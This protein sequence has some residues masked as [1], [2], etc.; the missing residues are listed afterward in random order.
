MNLKKK[1]KWKNVDFDFFIFLK[2]VS[3]WTA[4]S[5]SH[6]TNQDHL[7]QEKSYIASTNVD[8]EKSVHHQINI[9]TVWWIQVIVTVPTFIF[10][11]NEC[12][13]KLCNEIDLLQRNFEFAFQNLVYFR[14]N[15]IRTIKKHLVL[16]TDL[17]NIMID[18]FVLINNLHLSIINY[19]TMIKNCENQNIY[20]KKKRFWK[21]WRCSWNLLHRSTISWSIT[22]PILL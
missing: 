2:D 4:G 22:W 12:L 15:I 11:T 19:E 3:V 8:L 13:I 18:T 21:L 14:K 10:N 6:M 5:K 17:I 7:T 16:T 20:V 9:C 1:R